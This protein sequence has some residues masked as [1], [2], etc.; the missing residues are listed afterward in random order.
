MLFFLTKMKELVAEKNELANKLMRLEVILV[1]F[2]KS[3]IV[4]NFP[5]FFQKK[6]E[7]FQNSSQNITEDERRKRFRRTA[8][9]IDRHYK[10]I[11]EN[12]AKSYGSEGSLNQHIKL[13]HPDL[14][15]S[16]FFFGI[17]FL[18]F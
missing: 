9:E 1:F 7:D 15:V 6:T 16:A 2:V 17:V 11:V 8:G 4:L 18:I 13:K 14:Y 5:L 10:C 3:Y 12:C